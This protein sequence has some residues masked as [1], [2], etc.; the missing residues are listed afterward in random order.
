MIVYL[1][2]YHEIFKG[3]IKTTDTVNKKAGVITL[4]LIKHILR[5][6]ILKYPDLLSPLLFPL[7]S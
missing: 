1:V 3:E 5:F 6:Q 4:Y 2:A 7:S